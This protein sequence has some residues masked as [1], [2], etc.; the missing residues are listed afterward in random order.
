MIPDKITFRLKR[1]EAKTLYYQARDK[2]ISPHKLARNIVIEGLSLSQLEESIAL[3]AQRLEEITELQALC[4]QGLEENRQG[5]IEAFT[6]ILAKQNNI[7][8]DRAKDWL[9]KRFNSEDGF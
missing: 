1:E 3:L 6:V 5:M 9:R 2:D 7:T 8:E 4:M